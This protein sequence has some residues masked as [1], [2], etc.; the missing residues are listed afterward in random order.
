MVY[1]D[2]ELIATKRV[3]RQ[4]WNNNI[5]WD[6]RFNALGG[7]STLFTMGFFSYVALSF[8]L[9]RTQPLVTPFRS[10]AG[11]KSIARNAAFLLAPAAFGMF[12]GIS[13]AG[14][15]NELKNLS[16]NSS[17]YKREFAAVHHE[18]HA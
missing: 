10:P 14:D 15:W 16:R 2:Y 18:L 6:R 5:M 9:I 17:V 13:A 1:Q 7:Y 8:D 11:L 3:N 12:L 4:R